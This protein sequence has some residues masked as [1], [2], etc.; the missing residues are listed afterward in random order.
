MYLMAKESYS[1][2]GGMFKAKIEK[3]CW[4]IMLKIIRVLLM[5]TFIA[6]LPS[7]ELSL[8]LSRKMSNV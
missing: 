8:A 7:P 4:N 3:D 6:R 2:E 5:S 1:K